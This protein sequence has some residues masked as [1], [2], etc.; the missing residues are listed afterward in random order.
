M[1]ILGVK[2]ESTREGYTK[3]KNKDHLS[4]V[5]EEKIKKA[6]DFNTIFDVKMDELRE[7]HMMQL[8]EIRY[9]IYKKQGAIDELEDFNEKLTLAHRRLNNDHENLQQI[10]DEQCTKLQE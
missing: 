4:P 5:N 9:E 1:N 3:L 8:T 2:S 6:T 10:Y 7:A